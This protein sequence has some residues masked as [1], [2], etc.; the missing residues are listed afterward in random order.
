MYM[1][2]KAAQHYG[3]MHSVTATGVYRGNMAS[4]F[5]DNENLANAIILLRICK[6]QKIVCSG[7]LCTIA[8]K[9]HFTSQGFRFFPNTVANN[10]SKT[11]TSWHLWAGNE[12][13]STVPNFLSPAVFFVMEILFRD[14]YSTFRYE[15]KTL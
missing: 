1:E 6:R 9:I 11:K 10:Y 2:R 14:K 8:R 3:I 4:S 12:A 7:R 15:K 5:D 13:S